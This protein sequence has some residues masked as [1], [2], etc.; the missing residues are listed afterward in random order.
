[1]LILAVVVAVIAAAFIVPQLAGHPPAPSINFTWTAKGMAYTFDATLFRLGAPVNYTWAF[2]D[3]Q[4]TSGKSGS[5]SNPTQFNVTHTYYA[6]G[7]YSVTLSVVDPYGNT[8]SL[9]QSVVVTNYYPV[10][11]TLSAAI[12]G[13]AVTATVT[14]SGGSPPYYVGFDFGDGATTSTQR[15][16]GPTISFTH[17]YLKTG[18]YTVSARVGDATQN[19]SVATNSQTVTATY[20]SMSATL[21]LSASNMTVN[22][23]VAISGG[24][25]P[26]T[27]IFDWGDGSAA[28]RTSRPWAEHTYTKQGTYTVNV[29]VYDMSLNPPVKLQSTVTVPPVVSVTPQVIGIVLAG[30]GAVLGVVMLGERR[31][32][33]LWLVVVV[34]ALVAGG[35]VLVAGVI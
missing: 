32:R 10:S 23:S 9:T 17:T 35:A 5:E 20:N 8:G 28:T 30:A 31:L 12:Q 14:V 27:L 33:K 6:V 19:P 16:N 3:G 13:T 29:T 18:T 1:M 15:G 25:A 22:A 4:T 2:G 21:A 7:T 26:Y 11:G 24:Q 34:I